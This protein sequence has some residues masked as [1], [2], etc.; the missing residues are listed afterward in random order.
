MR[1][2][3]TYLT[4]MLA[5]TPLG[6]SFMVRALRVVIAVAAAAFMFAAPAAAQ[7]KNCQVE[8]LSQRYVSSQAW[9]DCIK[10]CMSGSDSAGDQ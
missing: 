4:A 10:A 9:A 2:R 6:W 8:C 5:A 3:Q 1:N 7:P